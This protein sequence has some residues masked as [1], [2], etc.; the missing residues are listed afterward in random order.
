MLLAR[1]VPAEGKGSARIGG[2]IATAS[3]LA[4][5][6]AVL[7]EVHGQHQAQRLLDQAVQT[8]FLDRFAG[9]AHLV[10]VAAYREAFDSLRVVTRGARATPRRGPRP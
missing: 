7:V 1:S 2:Q 6:G 8:A 9:D 4:S 10:A 3:T 5:L